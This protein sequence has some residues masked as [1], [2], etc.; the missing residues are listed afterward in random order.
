MSASV[1]QRPANGFAFGA[2][3]EAELAGVHPD[4]V[5]VTRRALEISVVDFSVHDGN[6]ELE[7]QRAMVESGASQTLKSNHLKQATGFGHAVDLV[8]Y[9]AGRERWEWVPIYSIAAAMKQAAAEMGVA[10]R[11]GGCWEELE[12]FED[13]EIAMR[14]YVGRRLMAGETPFADGP[15]YDLAGLA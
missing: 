9:I 15:H 1:Q 3:S 6:R 8:P 2:K 11:W 10:I 14:A 4:L 13:P 12:T 5:L 7:D